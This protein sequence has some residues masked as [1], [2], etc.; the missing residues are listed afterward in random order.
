MYDT[1][2]KMPTIVWAPGRFEGGRRIKGMC[3][4]FDLGPTILELAGATIDYPMAAQSLVPVLQNSVDQDQCFRDIVF[5]EQARDGNL[6][7]TDFMTMVRTQ[8][9]KLV[10]FLE[11]S[12]GQLFD[13]KQDPTEVNNLWDAPEHKSVKQE[14]L[15]SLREWRIRDSFNSS[16]L[17]KNVR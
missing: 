4:Q 13:L 14:L 7:E 10:H 16:E 2:T 3:Q 9:W 12:F 17:W 5:A 15:G 8:D 6:T 1:I 11:E